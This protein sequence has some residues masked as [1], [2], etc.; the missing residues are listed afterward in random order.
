[1]ARLRCV[2]G[3]SFLAL[4]GLSTAAAQGTFGDLRN[5]TERGSKTHTDWVP[6][7]SLRVWNQRREELRGQVL[8]AAGL[9]PKPERTP[10]RVQRFGKLQKPHYSIE[11][12]IF[13]SLP[14]L[15]VTGNLYLPARVLDTRARI[16]AVLVAHGHWKHGRVH[17]AD[18]YSVPALCINLAA[19]GYAVFT[20]DMVGYN[21]A[22]QLPH[23]F[24]DSTDE[25]LWS[26]SPL[27]IQMWNAIRAIDFMESL[28]FV[29]RARIGMTG[30]S[31]GGTQ[32]FLTAAVDERIRVAVPVAMVSAGFQGDDACEIAPSLRLGTNNVEITAMIAPR[33]L[34][35]VSTTK[36]WTRNTPEE[37]FPLLRSVYNLFGRTNRVRQ[38]QIDAPHNYNQASREHVY[39]FLANMLKGTI[40]PARNPIR[41]RETVDFDPATLLIGNSEL[42]AHKTDKKQIFGI[43]KSAASEAVAK[44]P[45]LEWR[46]A[47]QYASGIRWPEELHT[48]PAGSSTVLTRACCGD[49]VPIQFAPGQGETVIVVDSDG[50]NEARKQAR[51]SLAPL[52]YVDAFQT[53][54]AFTQ[55]PPMRGD[56]L[57][58]HMSD[59]ANRVQ[60]I[61]TAIA[62]V[63]GQEKRT[64]VVLE[65]SGGNAVRWCEVGAALSRV[66]VEIGTDGSEAKPVFIPGLE[67]LGGMKAVHERRL[68]KPAAVTPSTLN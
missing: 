52:L 63:A 26:F 55:R 59:D 18:D 8:A 17:H 11:K 9:L 37:E 49:R 2:A 20:W 5:L 46:D 42:L 30:A 16:P 1:M 65:C 58:F 43:W 66:P 12:V 24:G 57:T 38:V 41:E 40:P 61:L 68:A 53:G 47:L 3:L 54:S 45:D 48:I 7:K 23:E 32:T 33:P 44:L 10:L 29:D 67:R 4:M 28:D 27:G 50:I 31:G 39:A 36:D 35:V 14:G 6:P 22:K 15:Q 62:H 56:F 25:K 34:L 64:S 21:D 19:Q 51:K 60:D 13:E